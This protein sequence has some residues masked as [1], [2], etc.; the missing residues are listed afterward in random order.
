M[1]SKMRVAKLNLVVAAFIGGLSVEPA[2]AAGPADFFKNREVRLVIG[3]EPGTTYD[4]YARSVSRFLAKHLPGKVNFVAVN[5]PGA[6][7]VVALNN[8]YNNAANDGSVIGAINPGAV[9]MPILHPETALYDSRKFGWIGSVSRETEVIVVRQDTPVRTLAD[10][11]QME[12]IVGGTGGASSVLP[13]MLNGTIGTKF[14]VVNGYK[15]SSAAF[16]AMQRGEV[17]GVGSTTL[18]NLQATQ[19][20]LLK[21]NQIRIIGQYGL[22]PNAT[23]PDVPTV[24]NLVKNDDQRSIFRLML[25][26]QEI[27]RVM[28][29]P[30]NLPPDILGAYRAAFEATMA[31]PEFRA[32]ATA[33]KMDFDPQGAAKIETLVADLYKATPEVVK[34]VQA[35][36]GGRN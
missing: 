33:R 7:S 24:I 36:L 34:K 29:T 32:E 23:I 18:T 14:K 31:D 2:V 27:G 30:P 1:K 28:L 5:M 8:L 21:S 17:Q 20:E 9:V 13:T 11:L 12:V 16:L 26:R 35:L 3:Q 4:L 15:G 22:S 19:G 10:V 25:T 6:G